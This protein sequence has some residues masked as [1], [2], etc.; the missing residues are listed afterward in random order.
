M[1]LAVIPLTFLG[2]LHVHAFL[3]EFC[4]A[5]LCMALACLC[6]AILVVVDAEGSVVDEARWGYLRKPP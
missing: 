1:T 2:A 4:N 5:S 6:I 3:F